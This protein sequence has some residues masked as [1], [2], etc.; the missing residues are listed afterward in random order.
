MIATKKPD[1]LAPWLKGT[2][3]SELASFASGIQ[4][5]EAAV[6]A[7]IEPWSNGQTE[8]GAGLGV[9]RRGKLALV[10]TWCCW[11]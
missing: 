3:D 11:R 4:A 10:R 5:D 2:I 1:D 6:R 7:A 9:N 8:A